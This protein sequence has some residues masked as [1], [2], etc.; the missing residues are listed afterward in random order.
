MRFFFWKYLISWTVEVKIQVEAQVGDRGMGMK[1][2]STLSFLCMV[3]IGHHIYNHLRWSHTRDFLHALG[4]CNF[5]FLK[6]FCSSIFSP[7]VELIQVI[8]LDIT[9]LKTSFQ[10]LWL[11]RGKHYDTEL[12]KNKLEFK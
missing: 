2:Y 7:N 10:M 4:F 11:Y 12:E 6:R 1:I 8:P 9:P 3:P 5:F